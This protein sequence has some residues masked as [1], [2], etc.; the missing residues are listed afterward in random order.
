MPKISQAAIDHLIEHS[1]AHVE[2]PELTTRAIAEAQK[3]ADFFR[4]PAKGA[5]AAKAGSLEGY[6]PIG[7]ERAVAAAH[8]DPK[9]FFHIYRATALPEPFSLSSR[10]LHASCCALSQQIVDGVCSR[11]GL[12]IAAQLVT[13]ERA[14]LRAVHYPRVKEPELAAAHTDVTLVS[15]GLFES[16]PGLRISVED[17]ELDVDKSPIHVIALV[18]DMLEIASGGAVQAARHRVANLGQERH[19]LVF[20]GNPSDE[21]LLGPNLTARAVLLARLE[22]MGINAD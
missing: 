20:F 18:G 5:F 1:W 8:P 21:T 11:L 10:W 6:F 16:V 14:V 12:R 2:A 3:W 22:E 13:S 15:L 9:E 19:S 7:S 4:S 17:G